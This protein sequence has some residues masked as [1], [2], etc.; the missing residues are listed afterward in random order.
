MPSLRTT[1][2]ALMLAAAAAL[3]ARGET[4]RFVHLSDIHFDPFDP[5]G[6]AK[7]RAATPPADWPSRLADGADTPLAPWGRDTNAALLGSALDEAGRAAADADFVLVTGD[8]LAHDFPAKTERALGLPRGSAA[9]ADIA[10]RT[11]LYVAGRL[12]AAFPGKPVLMTLGNTDSG[13]GDYH[14]DPGGEFLAATRAAVRE[15][16]GPDLLDPGFDATFAAGG[17]YAARHPTLADTT[18][19][20]IDDVLWS[21]EYRDA[22][23]TSA[24][25]AAE[26]MM[27]WL[28]AELARNAAAGRK[29]WLARHIPLGLDPYA[30]LHARGSTC[31]DRVVP[32]FAPAYAERFAGLLARFGETITASF[33]GHT[34]HDDYRL[35]RRA[36]GTLAGVE[37][38]VP[39]ISP[40]YGQ[41]P[42]FHVFSY[43]RASGRPVD[44][45]TR[46]LA[47]LGD[48]PTPATARWE[49]E[50]RFTTAYGLGPY[51]PEAV[52]RLWRGLSTADPAA[53]TYRRLYDVGH[54]ELGVDEARAYACALGHAE[55]ANFTACFCR[56]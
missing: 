17:Y 10:I 49:T 3:P 18:V 8:L 46:Y 22:C 50:Y 19:I 12:R 26:A 20:V 39:A 53:T 47:N 30:S 15:L 36:D 51:G 37:K 43:D 5:L 34:H 23:G 45:E 27:A 56:D 54:R 41:N 32:M 29:V 24:T 44:F 4:G 40:V 35:L 31:P 6:A 2:I 25:A 21:A 42:G 55:A 7:A 16:A 13:C 38:I 1:L 48:A 33:S 52:E 9:S 28:E 11:A 14:V